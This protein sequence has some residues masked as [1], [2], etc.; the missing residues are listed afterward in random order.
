[1]KI[2]VTGTSGR[3]GRAIHFHLSKSHDVIGIDRSPASATTIISDINNLNTLEKALDGADAVI[4]TAA[5][6]LSLIHI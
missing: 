2:V 1:M 3:I 4:H 5:L 6:H